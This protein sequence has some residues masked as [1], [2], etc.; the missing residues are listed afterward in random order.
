MAQKSERF[1][2]SVFAILSSLVSGLAPLYWRLLADVPLATVMAYRVLTACLILGLF[3]IVFEKRPFEALAT[4][5]LRKKT[6]KIHLATAVLLGV[7]WSLMVWGVQQGHL[8]AVSLGNY[9]IP[10]VVLIGSAI[11]FSEKLERSRL[12]A[13]TLAMLGVVVLSFGDQGIPWLAIAL[14]L[15]FG[16]YSLLRKLNPE[17]S[18]QSSYIDILLLCV[19]AIPLIW[20]SSLNSSLTRY[21]AI[22]ASRGRRSSH[23]DSGALAW[24][25]DQAV[26]DES[27]GILSVHFSD[28][29]ICHRVCF[30]EQ[31]VYTLTAGR[32]WHHLDRHCASAGDLGGGKN[33][34]QTRKAEASKITPPAIAEDR[35]TKGIS[36]TE[37][38]EKCAAGVKVSR[39]IQINQNHFPHQGHRDFLRE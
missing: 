35:D 21:R 39:L 22:S 25:G 24:T 2:G 33:F 13:V 17:S 7:H 37:D 36:A 34:G 19:P 32:I 30:H 8:F 14:G 20:V 6:W 29:S 11:F 26:A 9:M 38:K 1:K 16:G 15:T 5:L 31:A 23:G 27:H 18:L 3:L 28:N 12:L 10:I 4:P